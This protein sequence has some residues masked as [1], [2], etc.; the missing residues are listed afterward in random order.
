MVVIAPDGRIVLD[1]DGQV[2]L[3]VINAAI[4]DATGL[5]APVERSINPGGSFNE[6]NI[7]VEV[8]AT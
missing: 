7:E 3:Q 4:S 8:N 6:V 2:P 1:Q 5:P